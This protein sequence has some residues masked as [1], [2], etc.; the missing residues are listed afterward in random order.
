MMALFTPTIAPV[1][2]ECETQTED[3]ASIFTTKPTPTH[4][5]LFANADLQDLYSNKLT[6]TFL[7][8]RTEVNVISDEYHI[9]DLSIDEKTDELVDFDLSA[10]LFPSSLWTLNIRSLAVHP[11]CSLGN[12]KALMRN[13]SDF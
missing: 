11:G 13:R 7:N 12:L 1:L 2:V 3:I 10:R 5:T 6:T 8:S 9:N 4:S